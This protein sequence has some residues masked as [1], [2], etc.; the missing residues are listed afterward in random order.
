MTSAPSTIFGTA[1]AAHIAPP[2]RV[3]VVDDNRD[4]ADSLAALLELEGFE[5]RTAHDGRE[6]LTTATDWRPDAVV[7]DIGLPGMD[8]YQVAAALRARFGRDGLQLVALTGYGQDSDREH[9][10]SA[11]FDRHL[12]KPV[13][14][15]EL[16]AALREGALRHLEAS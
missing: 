14:H 6:A 7:L 13:E 3:L 5:A 12:V 15:E 2:L 16:V 4:A 8:G 1:A 9:A 10:R 11:G